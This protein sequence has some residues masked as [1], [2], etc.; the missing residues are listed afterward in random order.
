MGS[1]GITVFTDTTERAPTFSLF[2]FEHAFSHRPPSLCYVQ[3]K[4]ATD[5]LS[6]WRALLKREPRVLNWP[7]VSQ[8]TTLE[9]LKGFHFGS[10]VLLQ[11]EKRWSPKV[12]QH[13]FDI[14]ISSGFHWSLD[15]KAKLSVQ[16]PE[17]K[18]SLY[19]HLMLKMWLNIHS[20]LVMGRLGRYTNNIMTW[21]YPTNGKLI[22]RAARYVCWL[23]GDFQQT[24]YEEAVRAVFKSLQEKERQ[25]SDKESVVLKAI[26]H[27]NATGKRC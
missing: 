4:G 9:Y 27:L 3:I 26:E 21:V 18:K 19:T 2:P 13:L 5:T 15:D 25:L 20:T 7:E 8:Q 12:Q 1:G 14:D 22:D 24:H 23:L 11:R 10:Q 17:L 16:R 6:A